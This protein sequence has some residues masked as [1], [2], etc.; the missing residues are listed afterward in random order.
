MK[1]PTIN[2]KPNSLYW[3]QQ[4]NPNNIIIWL[5]SFTLV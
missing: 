4:E 5:I 3:N 2:S 1:L